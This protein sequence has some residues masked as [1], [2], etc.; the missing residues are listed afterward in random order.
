VPCA[1]PATLTVALCGHAVSFYKPCATA[2]TKKS[3]E[4]SQETNCSRRASENSCPMWAFSP[5]ARPVEVRVLN[6]V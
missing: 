1:M 2:E 4:T 6:T 3:L 5:P